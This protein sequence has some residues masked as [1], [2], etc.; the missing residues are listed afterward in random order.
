MKI[1]QGHFARELLQNAKQRKNGADLDGGT[2]SLIY[3]QSI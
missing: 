1:K 2:L 3:C